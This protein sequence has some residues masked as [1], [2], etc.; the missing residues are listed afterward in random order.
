MSIVQRAHSREREGDG[1]GA[2]PGAGLFRVF[3]ARTRTMDFYSMDARKPW[4][5]KSSRNNVGHSFKRLPSPSNGRRR[6]VGR[7]WWS[8]G[9]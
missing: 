6:L 7:Q 1:V 2:V 3:E 9:Q 4:K 8:P 5:L